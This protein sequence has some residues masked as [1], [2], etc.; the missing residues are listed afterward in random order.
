MCPETISEGM[1]PAWQ[2]EVRIL[3]LFYEMRAA[4]VQGKSRL[5]K[6]RWKHA[7]CQQ[8]FCDSCHTRWHNKKYFLYK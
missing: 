7:S 8:C 2:L 4:G 1:R 6:P 3:R 5:L